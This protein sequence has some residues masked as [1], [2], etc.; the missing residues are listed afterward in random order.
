MNL[1]RSKTCPDKKLKTSKAIRNIEFY[2]YLLNILLFELTYFCNFK[3]G[4]ILS[5]QMGHL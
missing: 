3:T 2:I 4:S 5:C 1:K